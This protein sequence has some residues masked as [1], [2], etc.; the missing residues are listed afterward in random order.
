MKKRTLTISLIVLAIMLLVGIG[1]AG[2]VITRS[3]EGKAEGNF[4][5]YSVEDNG[6]TVTVTEGAIEYGP[7]TATAQNPWLAFT[8]NGT[9]DLTAT[10]TVVWT[11]STAESNA[12]FS[13]SSK[14]Y[15]VSKSDSTESSDLSNATL[16]AAPTFAFVGTVNNDVAEISND[17]TTL[18]LKSGYQGETLTIQVTYNWGSVFNGQN[19]NVYFN[20]HAYNDPLTAEVSVNNVT[21][22]TSN[23]YADLAKNA[24]EALDNL[25][26]ES[27]TQSALKFRVTI[28]KQ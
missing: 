11:G 26:K 23:N 16:I 22:T 7:V 13:L 4:T 8:G 3:T 2:W 19:P 9:Q 10:F 24:L 17:N 20:N 18:T 12:V 5:A 1:Y 14:L 15:K 28:A 27:D 6:L 25:V 21:L